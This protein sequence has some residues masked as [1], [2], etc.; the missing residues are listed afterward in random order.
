MAEERDTLDGKS[1]EPSGSD[2][3]TGTRKRS[4]KRFLKFLLLIPLG[5]LCAFTAMSYMKSDGQPYSQEID[6]ALIPIYSPASLN[7]THQ[8]DSSS[9]PMIASCIIDIDGDHIPELFLGGGKD[10]GDG[11]FRFSNGGFAPIENC[12]GVDKTT[13]DATYGAAT[14]DADS[15][16]D[17]DLFVARDSGV[18]LYI[19]DGGTFSGRKLD[20][21]LDDKSTPLSF[22]FADLNR[23]GWIDMYVSAYLPK[24][25]MEGMNIFNKKNYGSNSLLLVNNGDNTFTDITVD[26]GIRYTHNTFCGVFVDIDGDNEQDLVVAHDTGQVKTWKN[27]GD[28]KFKDMPNP[29]SDVYGYPM[30]IAVADYNNDGR[31]DFFFSNTGG[32]AP[33]FLAKGDLTDGQV[34]EDRLI[35]FRNDGEFK[36]TNVN[37]ETKTAKYEFSWGTVFHD[38]NLDGRQDLIISQNFVDFPLHRMFKLPGRVL[39]QRPDGT[40]AAT[41]DRSGVVNRRYEITSLV[42]DFNDDGYPDMVRVNLDGQAM[43]FINDGG[44]NHYLKVRIPDTAETMGT[45]VS[46][47]TADGTVLTDWMVTGEGLVCDQTH[48]LTFGFGSQTECPRVDVTYPDGRTQSFEN[49]QI[50]TTLEVTP[51]ALNAASA[52]GG[53]INE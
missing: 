29:T 45:K 23:D 46:V 36:F 8:Y 49:V 32:T 51:A 38:L 4:K 1:A 21:P 13:P 17:S 33:H 24:D 18:T 28:L 15:D 39:I 6:E 16:G 53:K 40:F 9:L 37:E 47:T 20:I 34:F 7:F 43:A 22:S 26:A 44:D 12:A 5:L 31:P 30:G 11:F 41:E 3:V 2:A 42:A 52:V 19:N 25:K 10:Q 27:M 50:D 35:F 48:V 14:I